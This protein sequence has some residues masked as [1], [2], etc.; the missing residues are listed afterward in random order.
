MAIVR[1]SP[2]PSSRMRA[3]KAAAHGA[4]PEAL[5]PRNPTI[6]SLSVCCANAVTGHVA[7]APMTTLMNARRLISPPEA[8]DKASYQVELAMSA[9]GQKRTLGHVRAM[10]ALPPKADIGTHSWN[11][12]FLQKADISA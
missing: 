2:Q 1:P 12:R 3:T 7:A 5:A 4:K 10:S 9:L 6:G 8:Q 11:V